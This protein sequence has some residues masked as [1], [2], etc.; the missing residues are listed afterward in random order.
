[1]SFIILVHVVFVFF[2][3]DI[4]LKLI[5]FYDFILIQLVFLLDLILI[6]LIVIFFISSFNIKLVV[7]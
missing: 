2:L 7:N 6:I 5:L 4:I 1:M 3:F